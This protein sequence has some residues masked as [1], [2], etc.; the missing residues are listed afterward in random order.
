[1]KQSV[2][3]ELL[4]EFAAKIVKAQKAEMMRVITGDSEDAPKRKGRPPKKPE[5]E[6]KLTKRRGRP[7]KKA[8]AEAE[9]EAD[10]EPPKRRGRPPK[11]QAASAEPKRRGR[12]PKA[13]APRK[14]RTKL[15]DLAVNTDEIPE[16]EEED[17]PEEEDL[18]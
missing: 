10:A 18:D 17:L 4:R 16:E 8:E 1:M 2:V 15:E 11:A 5:A 13:Q 14:S 3:E 7:P 12:P 6:T 9:A